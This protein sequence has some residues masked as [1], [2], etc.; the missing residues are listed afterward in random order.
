MCLGVVKIVPAGS[1]S[2]N[3]LLVEIL[4]V[5]FHLNGG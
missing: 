3:V 4:F 5:D 1:P 2:C